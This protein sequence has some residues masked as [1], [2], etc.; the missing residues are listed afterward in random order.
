MQAVEKYLQDKNYKLDI[1]LRE[2]SSDPSSGLKE[3]KH[4]GAAKFG[5]IFVYRSQSI[6]ISI[7][8]S[9]KIL[10]SSTVEDLRRM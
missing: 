3:F 1:K 10:R 5:P 8:F 6:F 4:P 7:A 2:E 9:K